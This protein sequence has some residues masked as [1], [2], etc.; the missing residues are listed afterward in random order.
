MYIR[1]FLALGA[2]LVGTACAV[3]VDTGT[4]N[5]DFGVTSVAV[6]PQ[7]ATVIVG[8]SLQLSAS[9]LMSNNRPPNSVTWASANTGLATVSVSGVVRARSVGTLFI[10]ATSGSKQD[11][12]ALTVASPSPLPVASVTLTPAS[13][14]VSVGGTILLV[15]TLKDANGNALAG[16]AITWASGNTG[17]ATVGGTGVVTA[18][19]AGSATISATSE[20][21][22]ASA[23][24]AVTTVPVASVS[25]SPATASVQAGQVVQ[26]TATPKD[27]NGSALSGRTVTWASSNVGVATVSGTGSVSG[28]AAGSATITATSEGQ[29][30]SAS[31]AVTVPASPPGTV[32]DLAVTAVTDSSVTLRFT[33]VDGG[34]GV[35]ASYDIRYATGSTLSWGS[36][37]ASVSRGTCATPVAGTAIG[38]SRT[39]TVLGLVASATYS[40]ELVAFRGTLTV[41]AVFGG[42]SNVASGTTAAAPPGGGGGGGGG[43][44]GTSYFSSDFESGTLGDLGVYPGSNGTCTVTTEAART[45]TRAAKCVTT[46]SAAAE[47]ALWYTWGNKPGEPANPALSEANGYYQKFSV[48]YAPGSFANVYNGGS[49]AQFKMVLNRSDWHYGFE[50]AWFMT[51]WGAN[52]GSWPPVIENNGD[53]CSGMHWNW[54]FVLQEGVWYDITT[55][56]KR[57]PTT[58]TGHA[59]MWVN[60]VLLSDTDVMPP[61]YGTS[62]S[63]GGLSCLGS[64]NAANQQQLEVGATYTKNTVGPFTVYVDDVQAANYPI[65]AAAR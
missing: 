7:T 24:V 40:F 19:T 2:V 14:T 47:G 8:D 18:A 60:G 31:I 3:P 61:A 5:P 11:S 6:Q 51:S 9:V 53:N 22:S 29:N 48:M 27:A 65:G 10:R 28:V 4:S 50:G 41:N 39:C 35:P 13:A 36:N 43:T 23:T 54:P 57:D 49:E 64:D 56:F 25:V 15:A 42:L 30:G 45:G 63:P 32:G 26:L 52:Y 17:V 55:W 59:K 16:R 33:E 38:A 1:S 58:H 34:T 21:Q 62:G 37:T 12:S 20:G 46:A 44:S